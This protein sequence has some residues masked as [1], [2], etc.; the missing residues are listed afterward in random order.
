MSALHA[1]RQNQ[2]L[3]AGGD[4]ASGATGTDLV[5]GSNIALFVCC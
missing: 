3:G 1:V 4:N 2:Q 5:F